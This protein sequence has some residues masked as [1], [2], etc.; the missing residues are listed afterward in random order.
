MSDIQAALQVDRLIGKHLAN[1][2]FS[3]PEVI[4]A[5][6]GMIDIKSMGNPFNHYK[7]DSDT[8]PRMRV[9]RIMA[10]PDYF[11]FTCR[12]LFDVDLIPF[13]CA[14]LKELWYRNRPMLMG[15]RGLGKTSLLAIY[16]LLRMMFTPKAKVLLCGAAFR[17]SKL[18]FEYILNIWNNSPILQD[19]YKNTRGAHSNG[20]HI[21]PD[22]CVFRLG[23]STCTAIP[24]GDGTK[25]RGL[26]ATHIIADEIASIPIDVFN[27]VIV[28]F[29]AVTSSPDKNV[30]ALAKMNLMKA[31]NKYDPDKHDYEVP[32]NQQVL[33]GTAFYRFNHAYTLWKYYHDVISTRGDHGK[34]MELH[35][36]AL[37]PSF[38]WKD[39]SIIRIPYDLV[40]DGFMDIKAIEQQEHTSTPSIFQMEYGAVF[41]QDSDGFFRRS[42]IELATCNEPI[43][44]VS[45]P[46]QFNASVRGNRGFDYVYGVDPASE[47]DNLAIVILELHS[48]HARVVYSWT[49][50]KKDHAEKVRAGL[51]AE[52]DYYRF[53]ARKIRDLMKVFPP[54][55]IS[56]DSGGGGISIREALGDSEGL[57]EGQVPLYPL[58]PE[59]PLHDGKE[60]DTDH[61][62]G[63]HILEMVTFSNYDYVCQANHGMKKD[64]LEKFLLFPV[65][66]AVAIA[67]AAVELSQN[68]KGVWEASNYDTLDDCMMEIEKL[69]D[70]LCTI[71]MTQTAVTGREHWDTPETKISGSKKGRQRK[72][73]YSALLMANMAARRI[74]RT[75]QPPA[76]G[77]VG[78]LVGST[79]RTG[80][81]KGLVAPDWFTARGY[82]GI[83]RPIGY[84]REG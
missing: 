83:G 28:G 68:D 73:R 40:P 61:K 38:N 1:V 18:I 2:D 72:D 24:I 58:N 67:N 55:L 63:N 17:Q 51:A 3:D 43:Q 48:D 9:V 46:V 76:Y 47:S 53:A 45:G 74:T 14:C 35:D 69:K 6:S 37:K 60:R 22:R 39:Y 11:N 41:P 27:T 10:N 36:G 80:L 12:H 70:E 5:L 82:R 71:V 31:L 34:L 25:I 7:K 75:P 57:P 33:S 21:E 44:L 52:Q 62:H 13:Q 78:G 84:S 65:F 15:T 19:I 32:F 42:I 56:I 29:G 64:L 79:K 26:R 16:A 20:P 8:D 30:K 66:D 49:T 54:V 59:H 4:D 77:G 50:N 81:T 23:S